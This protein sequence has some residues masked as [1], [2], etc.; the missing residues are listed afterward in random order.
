[1]VFLARNLSV[2][3][4]SNAKLCSERRIRDEGGQDYHGRLNAATAA[5][6]QEQG[7]SQQDIDVQPQDRCVVG[8]DRAPAI[9]SFNVTTFGPSVEENHLAVCTELQRPW[10]EDKE[11]FWLDQK[12]Q[13]QEL[14]QKLEQ[15]QQLKTGQPEAYAAKLNAAAVSRKKKKKMQGTACPGSVHGLEQP[16]TECKSIWCHSTK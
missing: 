7:A 15:Y 14:N 1:M 11:Y 16:C 2:I 4:V 12:T 9:F 6:L 5:K 13:Q 10:Q 3:T 8:E